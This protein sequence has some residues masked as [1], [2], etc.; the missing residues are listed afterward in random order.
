MKLKTLKIKKYELIKL[1][2]LKS[3]IYKNLKKKNYDIE[4][5]NKL[6]IHFKKIL[7]IIYQYH[8]NNKVILFVGFPYSKN[9][10]LLNNLKMSK[11]YFIPEDVWVN[12]FLIN[13]NSLRKYLNFNLSKSKNMRSLLNIKVVPD[14]IVMFKS[15][16]NDNM[17]KEISK[18]DVP[19]VCFGN[20]NNIINKLTYL[21]KDNFGEI[22]IK[23]F[24]KFL[25]YSILKK[26]KLSK[27]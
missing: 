27:V 24:Y 5:L 22:K 25:I 2:L 15:P 16:S 21:L 11:H 4:Y 3:R 8:V 12:G 18:L 26:P 7:R 19:I 17:V 6:K 9:K 23:Q 1:H 14:L 20:D 10:N 13:K